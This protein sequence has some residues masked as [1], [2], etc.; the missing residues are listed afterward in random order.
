MRAILSIIF[1]ILLFVWTALVSIG[2]A[3]VLLGP[4]YWAMNAQNFWAWGLGVMIKYLLGITYEVRGLEH[5]PE[6][7]CIIAAKHQSTWDTILPHALL[8]NPAWVLKKELHQIP[9]VGWFYMRQGSIPVD[10]KGGSKA[11]RYMLGRAKAA[12]ELGRPII[13][14]PEGTR[15]AL[16]AEPDYQ[17]GVAGLYK[18]LKLPVVPMA[19][20]SG[21]YWG[22]RQTIKKPGK[23]IVEFLPPI[24]AG[25]DRRAF[26]QAL[27]TAVE[28]GTNRLVAEGRAAE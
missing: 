12:K 18:Q 25:L 9:F 14:F 13:I 16:D 23:I 10:R 26:M 1:N 19:L 7:A 27:E 8:K 21:L 6:G 2:G 28:D 15:A 11:M 3:P 22:R 24:E 17:P 5:V 20:N 4:W